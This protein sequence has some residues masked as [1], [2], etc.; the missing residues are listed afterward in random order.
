MRSRHG[1]WT[2]AISLHV[3]T[4]PATVAYSPVTGTAT[5]STVAPRSWSTAMAC[6]TSPATSSPAP[7]LSSWGTPT[8]TPRRPSLRAAE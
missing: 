8:R 1:A 2:C 4:L 3:M 7:A 5:S 6:W